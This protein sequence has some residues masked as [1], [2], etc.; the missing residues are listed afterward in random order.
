MRRRSF[1]GCAKRSPVSSVA[2]FRP[3]RSD[4]DDPSTFAVLHE[5]EDVGDIREDVASRLSA[6]GARDFES[7][8]GCEAEATSRG[9]SF[10]SL[11]DR[12]KLDSNTARHPRLVR[13]LASK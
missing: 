10:V 2:V 13:Q 3:E 1:R 5:L 11:M 6:L 12:F 8:E 9:A 4:P 7:L